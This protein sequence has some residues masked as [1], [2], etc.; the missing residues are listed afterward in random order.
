MYKAYGWRGRPEELLALAVGPDLTYVHV[1]RCHGTSCNNGSF[2]EV[3]RGKPNG[4]RC[5]TCRETGAGE[6]NRRQLQ[7]MRCTGAMDQCV[8]VQ[9]TD[10]NNP[11]TLLCGCGTPNLCHPWQPLARLLLPSGHKIYC[12]S[13]SLCNRAAPRWDPLPTLL[14]PL[15]LLLLLGAVWN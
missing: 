8:K 5:Y 1:Q 6:C 4:K 11:R 15:T 12:C 14:L 10:K 3:P 7:S 2:A 13:E 9:S